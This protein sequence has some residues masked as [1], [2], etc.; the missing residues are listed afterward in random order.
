MELGGIPYPLP[1]NQPM[2]LFGSCQC[3][4]GVRPVQYEG[5]WRQIEVLHSIS[6]QQT[7]PYTNLENTPN[8]IKR[9]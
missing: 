3:S 6:P 2:N 4:L 1:P 9:Y 8:E 5:T 7:K